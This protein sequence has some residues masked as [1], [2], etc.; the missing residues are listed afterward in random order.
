MSP[1]TI[2]VKNADGEPDLLFVINTCLEEDKLVP[3]I[4]AAARDFLVTEEGKALLIRNHGVFNYG[5]FARTIPF[6][7]CVQHQFILTD[8]K[9][10]PVSVNHDTNLADYLHTKPA[11]DIEPTL[12]ELKAAVSATGRD[13][14]EDVL[15][16]E[17]PDQDDA[18]VIDRRLD[19]AL[20]ETSK[21]NF[22]LL[23]AQYLPD[24]LTSNM[25]AD[26]LH[27]QHY[28]SV[29]DFAR[30]TLIDVPAFI[31]IMG[32]RGRLPNGSGHL[33]F[34]DKILTRCTLDVPTQTVCIDHKAIIPVILLHQLLG[35]Q[36]R[37]AWYNA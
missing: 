29:T 21:Y 13:A 2:L 34:Q 28:E 26:I 3:A 8:V 12:E 18:D 27:H 32:L 20:E 37:I 24:R 5:D 9:A 35:N 36:V 7:Y 1:K 22:D 15:G 19:M 14:I 33:V 31:N 4:Q 17:L 6:R 10:L 23:V 16:Y 11:P 25:A 30:S